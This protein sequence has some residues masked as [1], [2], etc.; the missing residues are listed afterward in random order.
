MTEIE[1][2]IRKYYSKFLSEKIILK[3]LEKLQTNAKK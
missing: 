2:R 1:K 3:L